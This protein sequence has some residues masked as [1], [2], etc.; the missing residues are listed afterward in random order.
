MNKADYENMI[1]R[2]LRCSICKWI[3]QIQIKSKKYASICPAIDKYNFHPYSG[4]GKIVLALS[5]FLERL[6][7]DEKVRDIVYKC[8]Q[9]GGCDISCKFLYTLEPLEIMKK[10]R[11]DLVEKGIGPLPVQSKF[12]ESVFSQNNP[13]NELP[14]NRLDWMTEDIKVSESAK[15]L[16]FVG[17]TSSYRRKEIAY[18]TAKILNY[19]NIEFQVLGVEEICCGSPVLCVGDK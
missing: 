5:L 15:T 14:K 16:F 8:T 6:N 7:L 12:V 19:A 4:G 1:Q 10:L 11:E 18:A 17:C 13:Y 2:C 9:C 3:P